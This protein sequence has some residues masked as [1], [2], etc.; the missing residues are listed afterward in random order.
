MSKKLLISLAIGFLAILGC[1]A[2]SKAVAL[3]GNLIVL[4]SNNFTAL[5][6]EISAG[7]VDDVIKDIQKA[8]SD[9]PFFLFINSPGGEVIAGNR[10]VE[11]LKVSPNVEVVVQT[12]ASMAA[13]IT[14][15]V[16]KRHMSQTGFL[17]FHHIQT[18]VQGDI[19]QVESRVKFARELQDALER[20]VA[21]RLGISPEK[22]RGLV[23]FELFLNFWSAKK[24]NAIDDM[25]LVS[26]NKDLIGKV[27]TIREMTIVGPRETEVPL[28][29]L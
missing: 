20:V 16:Q 28:C 18:N 17:M 15:S 23:G 3:T 1:L 19:D 24:L 21:G 2:I 29:P 11:Y 6:G 5:V 22:W 4:T 9:K 27:R 14:E 7:S 8:D 25:V 13:V 10:L 12:A 26:C